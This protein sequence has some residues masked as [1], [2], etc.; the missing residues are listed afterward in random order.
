MNCRGI[1]DP[2]PANHPDRRKA[3]KCLE[4]A[5]AEKCEKCFE[6]QNLKKRK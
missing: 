4:T 6:N 1:L 5:T 3:E 2:Y